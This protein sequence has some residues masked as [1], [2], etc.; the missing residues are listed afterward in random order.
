MDLFELL[1]FDDDDEDEEY[2]PPARKRRKGKAVPVIEDDEDDD[3]EIDEDNGNEEIDEDKIDEDN[4][5]GD[6]EE[7]DEDYEAEEGDDDEEEDEDD[8]EDDEEITLQKG[9]AEQWKKKSVTKSADVEVMEERRTGQRCANIEQASEFRK[10]IRDLVKEFE[11]HVAK[12]KQVKKYLVDLIED[13]REACFNMKYPGMDFDVE[14]IVTTFSDPSFKAWRAKISGVKFADRN[15]L[16]EANTKHSSNIVTSDRSGKDAGQI[17]REVLDNLLTAQKNDCKQILRRL[18]KHN[19]EAHKSAVKAGKELVALLDYFPIL[20][21]LQVADAMTRPLIYVQVPE[22]VEIVKQ[23][24]D[25][26][27]KKKPKEGEAPID[28]IIME[29][30]VP[31]MLQLKNVWGYGREDIGKKTVSAII[32]KYLMERMIPKQHIPTNFLSKQFATTE[33]TLH[34]YIVGTKYKGGA[35]MGKFKI[36][37]SEEWTHKQKECEDDVNKGASSSG[38]KSTEKPKGKGIGKKS[39]KSRDAA[40]IRDDTSKP[41]KKRR[42]EDVDDKEDEEEE[43]RDKPRKKPVT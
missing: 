34:K 18:I 31:D 39:G 32:Y 14:E 41:K 1:D 26:I 2:E 20:A 42:I 6:D 17:A 22:V 19:T 4:G 23:A 13:V 3:E 27:D 40:E 25:V 10:Y 11:T 28:E 29:Q 12:G 8:E 30:N 7:V 35:Q 43:D 9:R 24:Q 16:K 33:S 38:M 36:S 21:W 37:E 5:N 15:D